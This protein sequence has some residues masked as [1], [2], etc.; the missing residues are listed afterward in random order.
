MGSGSSIQSTNQLDAERDARVKALGLDPKPPAVDPHRGLSQGYD[1]SASPGVV[2]DAK[3]KNADWY[4]WMNEHPLQYEAWMLKEKAGTYIDNTEKNV[5]DDFNSLKE[6]LTYV[7]VGAVVIL[8][9]AV[10][11]E[12]KSVV[13]TFKD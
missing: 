6:I 8:G 7:A 2:A 5:K 13:G 4:Q 1:S 10:F 11:L 3:Q 9:G 12:A